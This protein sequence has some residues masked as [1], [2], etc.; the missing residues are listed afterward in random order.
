MACY[1]CY[2]LE[3]CLWWGGVD[4]LLTLPRIKPPSRSGRG[5]VSARSRLSPD[6][7]RGR[8]L[9]VVAHVFRNA[10]RIALPTVVG[11][12]IAMNRPT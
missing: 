3:L 9:R 5:V 1:A 8:E 10:Q 11:L 6:E 12:R 4:V 2:E 7:R